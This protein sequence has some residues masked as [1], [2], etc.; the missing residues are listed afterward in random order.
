MAWKYVM[1]NNRMTGGTEFLLPVIFP[2]KLVHLDVAM[3]LRSIMPG[4]GHGGVSALSAGMIEH[5][6]PV[7]LGGRSETLGVGAQPNDNDVIAT[8]SYRHGIR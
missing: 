7:G 1:F 8:Y 5:V 6:R 3:R 2:D 4:W